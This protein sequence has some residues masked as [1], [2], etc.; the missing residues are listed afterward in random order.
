VHDDLTAA[1]EEMIERQLVARGFVEPCLLEA[2]RRVPR[3]AFLSPDLREFAYADESLPIEAEQ[4]VSQPFIVALMLAA[5]RLGPDDRVLEIGTGSGY[6]AAVHM[7][8]RSSVSHNW[9]SMPATG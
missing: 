9:L 1:R 6:A 4:T 7:S 5:A 3:E 8:I 2:M